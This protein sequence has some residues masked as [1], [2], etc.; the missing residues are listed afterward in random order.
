MKRLGHTPFGSS[1]T[2]GQNRNHNHGQQGSDHQTE[3]YYAGH[4]LI[5]TTVGFFISCDLFCNWQTVAFTGTL[6][7][8]EMITS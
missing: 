5:S 4:R 7:T 6:I 3:N 2:R 8:D 1:K